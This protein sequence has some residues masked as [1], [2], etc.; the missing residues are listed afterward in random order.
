ME[1]TTAT[2]WVSVAE[3]AVRL[4]CDPKTIQ[5]R[6][7]P[8]HRRHLPSRPGPRGM[9]VEVP[10][11]AST[12]EVANALTVAAEREIRL[13]GT[14]VASVER[15]RRTMRTMA[16]ASTVAASAAVAGLAVL[17]HLHTQQGAALTVAN[18]NATALR[19]AMDRWQRAATSAEALVDQATE[20]QRIL[21][22]DRDRWRAIAEE[23]MEARTVEGQS[24]LLVP[25]SVAVSK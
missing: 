20:A 5:R 9:E 21:M 22:A 18:A 24:L 3:A 8:G 2:E 16:R 23:E 13:A 4:A 7:K 15:E 25:P 10:A 19:E 6:L 17:W 11:K 12:A 1:N 14:L